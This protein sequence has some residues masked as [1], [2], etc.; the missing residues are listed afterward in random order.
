MHVL[1][2][3][4]PWSSC[5]CLCLSYL[6][7]GSLSVLAVAHSTDLS[8]LLRFCHSCYVHASTLH[9]SIIHPSFQPSSIHPSSQPSIH[10]LTQPAKLPPP[11]KYSRNTRTVQDTTQNEVGAQELADCGQ[12]EHLMRQWQC[13]ETNTVIEEVI[14]GCDIT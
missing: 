9:P 1:T 7:F 2:R 11:S 5:D 12:Y 4:S 8:V 13:R 3:W 10:P 6:H 14:E